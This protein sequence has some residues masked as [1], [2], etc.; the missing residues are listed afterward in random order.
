MYQYVFMKKR[1]VLFKALSDE[2]RFSVVK[3]LLNGEKCVCEIWPK[4]KKTQSTVSIHLNK[5]ESWGVLESRRQ[6]KNIFYK[7]KD[8]RIYSILKVLH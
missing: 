3:I 2:T 7:I 8:K 1:I 5:L 6:G 4:V